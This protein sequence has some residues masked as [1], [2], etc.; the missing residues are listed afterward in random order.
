V[1]GLV[2]RVRW[3]G[4]SARLIPVWLTRSG[5]IASAPG[6]RPADVLWA[7]SDRRSGDRLVTEGKDG[8]ADGDE[9]VGG[10]AG[11]DARRGGLPR[12]RGTPGPRASP[13]DAGGAGAPS[14]SGAAHGA[15]DDGGVLR[16]GDLCASGDRLDARAQGGRPLRPARLPGRWSADRDGGIGAAPA[17]PVHDGGALD[18]LPGH[19]SARG[20]RHRGA[21]GAGPP[22]S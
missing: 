11:A 21:W 22:R 6:R 14:A 17:R 15:P 9:S 4:W 7:P 5:G 2:S 3:R 1:H 13:R 10:L 12:T 20:R 8:R 18:D 16:V 19:A